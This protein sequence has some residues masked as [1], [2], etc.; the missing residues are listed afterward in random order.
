MEYI[1]QGEVEKGKGPESGNEK[2]ADQDRDEGMKAD[3]IKRDGNSAKENEQL[4]GIWKPTEGS[5]R[6]EMIFEL[7]RG[8]RDLI[9]DAH[10]NAL[11][12]MREPNFSYLL[13]KLS[14]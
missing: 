7:E 9:G 11:Y 14:G 1:L 6:R 4:R 13:K 3:R 12:G 2:E 8:L 10:E 5:G